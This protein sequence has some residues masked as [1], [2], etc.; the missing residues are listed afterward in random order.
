MRPLF[1]S[2]KEDVRQLKGKKGDKSVLRYSI[3]LVMLN[4]L[5]NFN[6]ITEDEYAK[7][8]SRLMQDYDI[9]SDWTA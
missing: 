2:C 5:R 1:K 3:Q 8:K 6:V 4:K 9:I 7:I